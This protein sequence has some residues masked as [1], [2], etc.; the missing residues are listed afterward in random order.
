V[1]VW[2]RPLVSSSKAK[3]CQLCR[4]CADPRTTSLHEHAA[5]TNLR[6]KSIACTAHIFKQESPAVAR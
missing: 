6:L 5:A 1:T 4:L 2:A 3:S